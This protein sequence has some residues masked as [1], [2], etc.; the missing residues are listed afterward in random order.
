[1]DCAIPGKLSFGSDEAAKLPDELREKCNM[2]GLIVSF[3]P[4]LEVLAHR[5]TG[6][7]QTHF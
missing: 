1:M 5:A 6:M 7:I 4:Q 2:K 3:C